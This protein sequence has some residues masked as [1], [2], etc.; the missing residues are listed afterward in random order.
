M[1]DFANWLLGVIKE[2]FKAL[3]DWVTD[4]MVWAVDEV[5]KAVVTLVSAIP[6][7]SFMSSG[8]SGAMGQI[9]SDVW[10]FASHFRL[11]ECLAILGAAFAFRLVRKAVTLFQW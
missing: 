8:L 7:P 6:A 5:L 1:S 2:I 9:S 3:W 10:F 11:A 4:A